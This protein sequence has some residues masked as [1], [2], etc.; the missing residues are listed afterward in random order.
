MS[1]CRYNIAVIIL[2]LVFFS[3]QSRKEVADLSV[4]KSGMTE[5]EVLNLVGEPTGKI[6]GGNKW[7]YGK[8]TNLVAFIEGTVSYVIVD[9]STTDLLH[10]EG[11]PLD[12]Y[13]Y[14][15][16]SDE[17]LTAERTKVAI[18][19]EGRTI[20]LIT[21]SVAILEKDS[22]VRIHVGS[23]SLGYNLVLFLNK[24]KKYKGTVW[25]STPDGVIVDVYSGSSRDLKEIN[26]ITVNIAE[27]KMGGKV[28]VRFSHADALID[29]RFIVIEGV[30]VNE[31][32]EPF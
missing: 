23:D 29:E 22:A 1:F 26:E 19:N 4:I 28:V 20:D 8:E 21:N 32:R 16:Q 2:L 11:K 18:T 6:D 3:C 31:L 15:Y 24:D 30:V 12:D 9:Y 13:K 27:F 7:Y 5:Q 25:V 17:Q 14:T 10:G